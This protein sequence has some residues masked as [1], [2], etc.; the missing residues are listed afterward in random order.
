MIAFDSALV[1]ANRIR[2]Q[3]FEFLM[4]DSNDSPCLTR[5]SDSATASLDPQQHM[6]I[7]LNLGR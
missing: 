2:S 7:L 3:D 4:I 5:I 6:I 1:P